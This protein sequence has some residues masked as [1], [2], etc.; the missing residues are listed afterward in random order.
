MI[1]TLI[2]CLLYVSF[3]I[4]LIQNIFTQEENPSYREEEVLFKVGDITLSG[5]LTLPNTSGPHPAII[6]ISGSWADNRDAEINGFKPFRIIADHLSRNGIAV[7]RY[8]DRGVGKSTG[9]HTYQYTVEDFA[10]DVLAAVKV[11]KSHQNINK[12]HIGLCGHSLGAVVAP[13]SASKL[14]DISFIILMA[15]YGTIGE[16]VMIESRKL[17]AQL[18]GK[19]DAEIEKLIQ[20]E[21]RMC[22]VSRTGVGFD[23]LEKDLREMALS[24]FEKLS[25]M[26]KNSFNNFESYFKNTYNGIMLTFIPT[27]F[28]KHWLDYNP[29][30]SFKKVKCSTLIL[31]GEN[32]T[33]VPS[34]VNK[35][36][37]VTALKEAGNKDYTVKI[38]QKANHYFT[39][40][41][42]W[43]KGFA[44]G[45]FDTMINWILE[46]VDIAK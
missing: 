37:I 6:L 39:N 16:E 14:N 13:L 15:G 1:K 23:E 34:E 43:G 45:F 36:L 28:Y 9:K 21:K 35:P 30:P 40:S 44:P 18:A 17:E 8:D 22:N 7:L 25:K 5:T 24:D 31:F 33:T 2:I 19:T 11:L 32:D 10:D 38:I 26:K 3:S 46:R 12:E 20:L 4:L 27:P 29:L 42:N 41:S